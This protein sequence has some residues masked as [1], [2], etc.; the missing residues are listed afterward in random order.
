[1]LQIKSI[2]VV[3][4]VSNVI[5]I[6]D[7]QIEVYIIICSNEIKTSFVF[8]D[9]SRWYV[10]VEYLFFYIN[11]L[12]G[13]YLKGRVVV[14]TIGTIFQSSIY[15]YLSDIVAD[16]LDGNGHINLFKEDRSHTYG[17]HQEGPLHIEVLGTEST[18][19]TIFGSV[20]N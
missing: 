17:S 10:D 13:M 6:F 4:G 14:E 12:F 8:F 15:D 1:M 20:P 3:I 18:F 9:C 7:T 16:L 5:W 19:V 2:D 11:F